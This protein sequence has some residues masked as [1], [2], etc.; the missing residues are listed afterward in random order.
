M[1]TDQVAS[2]S[3]RSHLWRTRHAKFEN[4]VFVYKKCLSCTHPESSAMYMKAVDWYTKILLVR[5]RIFRALGSWNVPTGMSQSLGSERASYKWLNGG[6]AN[7]TTE[8][9]S[10]S[11]IIE[12]KRPDN[13]PNLP[14][15]ARWKCCQLCSTPNMIERQ[16]HA[17]KER[18]E[19]I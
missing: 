8:K 6:F 4:C 16:G 7:S 15:T 11:R 18:G 9:I 17:R 14:L 3:N 12:W 13:Q 2:V 19:I 5:S 10:M 1:G